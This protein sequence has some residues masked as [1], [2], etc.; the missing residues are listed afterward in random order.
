MRRVSL[1]AAFSEYF[2]C[3][4]QV[5][6]CS[7]N[8]LEYNELEKRGK[9]PWSA[10][11]DENRLVLS[12]FV[13]EYQT[14]E[15]VQPHIDLLRNTSQSYTVPRW[16]KQPHYEVRIEKQ[17]LADTFSSFLRGLDDRIVVNRGYSGWS[18]LYENCVRLLDVKRFWK[19]DSHT[20]FRR[21]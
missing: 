13:E 11:S 3:Y 14:P 20:I 7:F 19:R 6:Q 18:F 21:F 15:H 5:H 1:L 9:L 10:Y 8:D 17:A 2:I 12:D 16:Y 4:M